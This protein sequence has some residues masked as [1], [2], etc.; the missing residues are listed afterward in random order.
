MLRG[1]E[2]QMMCIFGETFG[3]THLD[4]QHQESHRYHDDHQQFGG[5]DL[6]V[7]VPVAHSGECHD[8]EVDRVKK[9]Q[10]LPG[11]L[12]VLDATYAAEEPLYDLQSVAT[13]PEKNSSL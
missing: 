11:T 1:K 8:A 7:D 3:D 13:L 2:N 4:W 12:Q 9:A 5:P 6:G 10:L